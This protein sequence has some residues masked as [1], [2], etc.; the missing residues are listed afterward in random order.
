MSEIQNTT[1]SQNQNRPA[2]HVWISAIILSVLLIGFLIYSFIFYPKLTDDQ[3]N[4]LRFLSALCGGSA[5]YFIGGLATI[6]I[7]FSEKSNFKLLF[8]ATS[9]IALFVF[10]YSYSPY[11]FTKEDR[12]PE[13][14]S[15]PDL[16]TISRSEKIDLGREIK[17]NPVQPIAV[18]PPSPSIKSS[19][20]EMDKTEQYF[21]NIETHCEGMLS[22]FHPELWDKIKLDAQH[23]RSKTGNTSSSY[24]NK[25]IFDMCK[26]K[27]FQAKNKADYDLWIMIV[28][29]ALIN[30]ND[31]KNIET[32][33][34]EKFID[35]YKNHCQSVLNDPNDKE[36]AKK[37]GWW[38]QINLNAQHAISLRGGNNALDS[39][40]QLAKECEKFLKDVT[41]LEKH[42]LWLLI[43][44]SAWRDSTPGLDWKLTEML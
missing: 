9:G 38:D 16:A 32:S 3:R 17:A 21:A 37:R 13:I 41:D 24:Y 25:V 18:T 30:L 15:M 7:G 40:R 8:S 11:W 20:P 34:N 44:A 29:S 14:K 5:A 39:N 6:E 31:N 42:N 27:L 2:P 22:K 23:E 1:K 26:S 43:N 36:Y 10:L 4:I 12:P 35:S 19:I 28:T 33:T